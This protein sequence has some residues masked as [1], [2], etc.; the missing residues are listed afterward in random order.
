LT[1]VVCPHRPDCSPSAMSSTPDVV[2][3][4][5]MVGPYAAKKVYPV[6]SLDGPYVH[7]V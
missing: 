4:L 7:R 2:N 6:V 3:V 1:F 5:G